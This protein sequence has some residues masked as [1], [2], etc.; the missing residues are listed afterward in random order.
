MGW[1]RGERNE[2]KKSTFNYIKDFFLPQVRLGENGKAN[3]HR[4]G[5]VVLLRHEE[6]WGNLQVRKMNERTNSTHRRQTLTAVTCFLRS[7]VLKYSCDLFVIRI[8]WTERERHVKSMVSFSSHHPCPIS[9][10]AWCWIEM[11]GDVAVR[12]KRRHDDAPGY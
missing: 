2:R 7:G 4:R 9:F 1:W 3:S 11:S 12:E 10:S 5:E 8:G 6:K